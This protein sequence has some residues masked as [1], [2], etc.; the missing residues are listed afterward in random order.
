MSLFLDTAKIQVKA[1]KGGDA[2]ETCGFSRK[3]S[4]DI[5]RVAKML[6]RLEK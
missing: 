4:R 5:R 6:A 1:G 2:R 3:A